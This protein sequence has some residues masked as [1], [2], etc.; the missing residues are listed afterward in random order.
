[1][2]QLWNLFAAFFRVGILGYGG[3]P[4][5]IPL[6]EAEAVRHYNWLSSEEFIDVLAMGNALPGPIATKM[7]AYI[8]YKVSGVT[9]SVVAVMALIG[10]TWIAMIGLFT[11][12]NLFKE[13]P[14]VQGMIAA[15][16]PV[17]VVLLLQLVVDLTPRSVTGGVTVA[18]AVIAAALLFF[19]RLHPALVV[20]AAL[21]FGALAIR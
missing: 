3:G 6:V 18:I 9:G 20:L 14:V 21:V 5:S 1:V 17:I 16:R 4:S 12:L 11:V 15:V 19:H 13:S 8:G 7:A 2:E 10:P